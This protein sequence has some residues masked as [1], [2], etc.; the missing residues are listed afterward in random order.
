MANPIELVPE[1]R[2]AQDDVKRQ[3]EMAPVEHAAAVLSVFELLEELHKNGTL[4]LLRGAA[5]ASGEIVKNVTELVASPESVR[6]MRNLLVMAQLLASIDPDTLHGV[7]G[8]L[9]FATEPRDER[10]KP[11]SIF[12]I[13]R[14]L[15]SEDSR[16]ALDALTSVMEG[17]GHGL[18]PRTK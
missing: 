16:Y 7:I 9:Q 3:I 10:Q 11:P 5:G 4:D 15:N 13:L 17:V 14:R 12:R 18:N 2:R 8:A 1:Q 6:A